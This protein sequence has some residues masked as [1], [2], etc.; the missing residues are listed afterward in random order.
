MPDL[1]VR[2][3][4]SESSWGQVPRF[5]GCS[6]PG[7]F[8]QRSFVGPVRVWLPCSPTIPSAAQVGVKPLLGA[9][10][11]EIRAGTPQSCSGLGCRETVVM[12]KPWGTPSLECS[13]GWYWGA[14]WGHP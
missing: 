6:G 3:T 10:S 7:R 5:L 11:L 9:C 14:A 8:A 12:A 1:P 4:E 2:L 13:R